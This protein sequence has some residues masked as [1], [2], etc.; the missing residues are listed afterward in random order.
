VSRGE[1]SRVAAQFLI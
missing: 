1:K